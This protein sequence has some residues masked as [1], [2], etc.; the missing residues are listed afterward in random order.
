MKKQ[1]SLDKKALPSSGSEWSDAMAQGGNTGKE[2]SRYVVTLR[3]PPPQLASASQDS[4][5]SS[6]EAVVRANE[7]AVDAPTDQALP[8]QM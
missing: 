3:P 2:S 4:P 1:K 6:T 5:C 8:T 7:S